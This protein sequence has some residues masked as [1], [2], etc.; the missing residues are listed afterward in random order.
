VEIGI[1]EDALVILFF[2]CSVIPNVLKVGFTREQGRKF[3]MGY[4]IPVFR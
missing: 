2:L 4:W 3:R 1:I